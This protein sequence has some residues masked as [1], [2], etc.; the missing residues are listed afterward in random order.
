M[1]IITIIAFLFIVYC[2]QGQTL[3]LDEIIQIRTM[4]SLELKTFCY[5]KGFKLKEIKEDN[6]INTYSYIS[7]TSNSI[8]FLRTF[9]KDTTANSFVY[10]YFTENKT[11]RKFKKQMKNKGFKYEKTKTDNYGG[12]EYKHKIYLTENN[13]IDLAS[14]RLIGQKIKHTLL[15]YRRVN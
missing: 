7:Q 15:Y 3:S 14:Q 6:W 10:Y 12:N 5:N 8:W 4:D 11:L 9:P 2:T 1:K 13:E